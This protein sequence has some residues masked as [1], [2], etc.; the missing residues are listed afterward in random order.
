MTGGLTGYC[1]EHLN[2]A[3]PCSEPGCTSRCAAYTKRGYC[4]EHR[5]L[6]DRLYRKGFRE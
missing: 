3:Y 5:K 6:G 2:V 1:P 4:A